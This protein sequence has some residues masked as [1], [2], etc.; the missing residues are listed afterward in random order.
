[1]AAHHP[2]SKVIICTDG[3]ANTGIGSFDDWIPEAINVLV[4]C[5]PKHTPMNIQERAK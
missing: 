2:G 3:E 5:T 1:M 4:H